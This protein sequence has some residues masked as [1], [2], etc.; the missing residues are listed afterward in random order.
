[1]QILLLMEKIFTGVQCTWRNTGILKVTGLKKKKRKFLDFMH[2]Y[3]MLKL[4][5]HCK[6][7]LPFNIFGTRLGIKKKERKGGNKGED[8][9]TN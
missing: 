6:Y 8:K 7:K 9:D 1:M 3:I 2:I 4:C 5:P